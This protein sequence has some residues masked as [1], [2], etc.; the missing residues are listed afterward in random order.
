MYRVSIKYSYKN[1]KISRIKTESGQLQIVMMPKFILRKNN[2]FFFLLM[3]GEVIT[4][5]TIVLIIDSFKIGSL[6][7]LSLRS[8]KL[9][10]Y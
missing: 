7:L 4:T 5:N 1:R 9:V 10:F 8:T 3:F 6:H 2:K